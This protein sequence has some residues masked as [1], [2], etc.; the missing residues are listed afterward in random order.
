MN[1]FVKKF[2]EDAQK[3]ESFMRK[4]SKAKKRFH[5]LKEP[6]EKICAIIEKIILPIAEEKGYNF[7]IYDLLVFEE[8]ASES[9]A[10]L[11]E[12][13]VLE[14][15]SGGA[16]KFEMPVVSASTLLNMGEVSLKGLASEYLRG[17]NKEI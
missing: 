16:E 1:F 17:K 12:E 11:M 9:G 3:D 2:Y 14:K 13:S 10:K 15:V 5:Y 8:E 6:R 4:I 7:D